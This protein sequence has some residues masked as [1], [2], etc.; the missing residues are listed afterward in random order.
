MKK[1]L[2]FTS[3][4]TLSGCI[5]AG[6]MNFLPWRNTFFEDW[7]SHP[8]VFFDNSEPKLVKVVKTAEVE[9]AKNEI[10]R[11]YTGFSV[12][13]DKKYQTSYYQ[14]CFVKASK[15]GYLTSEGVPAKINAKD[16]KKLVGRVELNKIW[17]SLLPMKNDKYVYLIQEDGVPYDRIGLIKNDRLIVLDTNFMVRPHDLRFN[18]LTETIMN[19][20][21][22]TTGFD[23]KYGG[24]ESKGL[25]FRV[26]DYSKYSKDKGSFENLYFK[27][28]ENVNI[29]V[30]G[31]K[32][33]VLYAD[34]E[35]IDYIILG[36]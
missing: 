18:I 3:I 17:Y 29:K 14:D 13:Y 27:Y 24:L 5:Y 21:T 15:D 22:P 34:K 23:I 16:V 32:I 8:I 11:A 35:K 6:D 25:L 4:L 30:M 31:V 19:Q 28:K 10:Q 12:F 26:L 7:N 36:Y 1:I 20:T 33:K 9:P 2:I